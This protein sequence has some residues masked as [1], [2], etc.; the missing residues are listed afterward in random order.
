MKNVWI[1]ANITLNF[2]AKKFW[3]ILF[4]ISMP[5]IDYFKLSSRNCFNF[6]IASDLI[7][8]CTIIF[9]FKFLIHVIIFFD[10]FFTI[11][12]NVL[13]DFDVFFL[14]FEDLTLYLSGSYDCN[15]WGWI[16]DLVSHI[17]YFVCVQF[18]DESELQIFLRKS[19]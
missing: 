12:T 7:K 13:N 8:C 17:T 10:G 5:T 15:P 6:N 14:I 18:K 4:L 16:I 11:S 2:H 19:A 1:P 3:S 9:P